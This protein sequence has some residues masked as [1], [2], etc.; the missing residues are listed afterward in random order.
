M[1][2][3]VDTNVLVSGVLNRGPPGR[4]VDAI[5]AETFTVLYD[6][7]ILGEY[8]DVLARPVLDFGPVGC[9]NIVQ[10]ARVYS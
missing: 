6:D 2:V 7:R 8:R 1:R 10:A 3:V 5:V 9:R 4:I